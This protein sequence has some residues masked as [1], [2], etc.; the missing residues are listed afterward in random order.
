M[1]AKTYKIGLS[2]TD[3][4]NMAQDIYEQVEELL[5]EEYDSSKTYNENDYVVYSGVL[6]RALEDNITG[7]WDST[8]WT[9]ATLNDLVDEVNSAVASVNGKANIIDLE[10]GTLVPEKSSVAKNL[11]PVSSASGSTQTAPFINQGTA[12]NNNDS[13]SEVDTG[14]LGQHL[15]KQGNTL[16]VN[17]HLHRDNFPATQTINGITFTKNSDNSYTLS[18]TATDNAV[19]DLETYQSGYFTNGHKYLIIAGLNQTGSATTFEFMMLR[20]LGTSVNANVYSYGYVFTFVH[21]NE[22]VV[23]R[24]V[25]RNGA[26][27]SNLK[28]SP[29]II[30]ITSWDTNIIT[31][32]TNNPS[33]FSWYYNGDLSYNAG[34]L[35]NSNGRYIVNGGQNVCDEMLESG[36]INSSGQE[37]SNADAFRTDNFLKVIPNKTYILH[38]N[39]AL[40]ISS[41]NVYEY[42]K[43]KNFITHTS[44]YNNNSTFTLSA[45]TMYVRLAFYKASSGWGTNAPTKEQAQL[46]LS[47]YYEGEDYTQYIPYETPKA[48]DTGSEVLRSAGSVRDYKEPNG[49]IHR[50]V[51]S[52]TFTGNETI[53]DRGTNAIGLQVYSVDV[54]QLFNYSFNNNVKAI[55]SKAL[56]LG[57]ADAVSAVQS[58]SDNKGFRLYYASGSGYRFIYFI[59]LTQ[60]EITGL[61]LYY[62]L[63]TPTTEQGT[64]FTENMD[65]N[66]MGNMAWYSAYT[67]ETTNTLVEVP[68]GCKIFYPAWYVGFLDTLGQ[69][70]DIGWSADKIVSK[71]EL[72]ASE[73]AR[74]SIDTQLLN[75]IGGTLR[76][77]LCVKESLDF[78]NTGVVDLGTLSWAYRSADN[79]FSLAGGSTISTLKTNGKVLSTLYK[80]NITYADELN[81]M[82]VSTTN[83]YNGH[84]IVI[85]N[86]SYTDAATFKNAMKGV[87]LAYEK[88]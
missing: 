45:T 21:S 50:L 39:S 77:C 25:V 6:Y 5:F 14:T 74:D 20:F 70:E 18:G 33:H 28:V 44:K 43:N 19:L 53:V 40:S 48:Y 27:V 63:A 26:S 32:L 67:D 57:T 56:F 9:S 46:T 64:A 1:A 65:I 79:V 13:Q 83:S 7:T 59:G 81:N 69:R 34:E 75:A 29:Y 24:I 30:D 78:N 31:D 8:K 73:T 55:S 49:T 72:S 42:D 86:T 87:L 36:Y 23:A 82:E 47:L 62:E 15:E 76:Q 80:T 2:A 3:K 52:Y 60:V 61:V 37:T 17:Q 85:K 41:F 71:T 35:I 4:Q 88:A 22:T 38:S 66:D 84:D 10:N 68:Q 54:S 58:G 11:E 12:T 51:G 16:V